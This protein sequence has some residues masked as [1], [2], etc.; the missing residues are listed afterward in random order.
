[1]EE[2]TPTSEMVQAAKAIENGES[3][4]VCGGAGTGK[5]WFVADM[6]SQLRRQ[7]KNV[8]VVA[9][10]ANAA[11]N[12]DGFTIHSAFNLQPTTD[13]FSDTANLSSSVEEILAEVD[14]LVI[15]EISMVSAQLLDQVALRLRKTRGSRDAS[16]IDGFGHAFGSRQVILVGD[17]FQIQPIKKGDVEIHLEEFGYKSIWWFSAK[18]YDPSK[19]RHFEFKENFRQQDAPQYLD[20]LNNL[21]RGRKIL[22]DFDFFRKRHS[23]HVSEPSRECIHLVGTNKEVKQIN[24]NRLDAISSPER[25]SELVWDTKPSEGDST[26]MGIPKILTFKIGAR[27]ILTKNKYNEEGRP[28]WVNGSSGTIVEISPDQGSHVNTIVVELDKGG[29]RRVGRETFE[30]HRPKL[31]KGDGEGVKPKIEFELVSSAKQFPFSLGWAMTI[32]KS[33]GATLDGVAV[34]LSGVFQPGM[35]YVALSRTRR[36]EDLLITGEVFAEGHVKDIDPL[37]EE[38]MTRWFEHDPEIED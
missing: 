26:P 21:R 3:I 33:Q 2:K 32:H 22:K 20:A 35:A 37:L 18:S 17:P 1:M 14:V 28:M 7:N 34:D 23:S 6:V 9:P 25:T 8:L 27:I 19:L 29:R 15:D 4:L 24:Q 11:L 31:I 10:T 36:V 12:C 30:E 5:T 38:Y 16:D 13:L